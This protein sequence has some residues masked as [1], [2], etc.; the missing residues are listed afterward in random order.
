MALA[1]RRRF[2]GGLAATAAAALLALASAG[3]AQEART[4]EVAVE[5]DETWWAGVVS[6]A[7]R[8]PLGRES[9]AF[10]IEYGSKLM[11]VWRELGAFPG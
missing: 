7:H 3:P 11:P 10:E 1:H 8:M 9:A 4:L 5:P 6:E 2:T